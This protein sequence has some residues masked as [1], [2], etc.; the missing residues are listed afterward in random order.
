VGYKVANDSATPEWKPNAEF[1]AA[2][3][4]SLRDAGLAPR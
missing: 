3:E 2:R 1:K 4:K